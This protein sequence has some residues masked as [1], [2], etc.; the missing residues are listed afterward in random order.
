MDLYEP[1]LELYIKIFKDKWDFEVF[2]NTELEEKTDWCTYPK[3]MFDWD[4]LCYV[5]WVEWDKLD[6]F[7]HELY[8]LVS[9]IDSEYSLG[10]ETCAYLMWWIV[11]NAYKWTLITS[12]KWE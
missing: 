3:W 9:V 7:I 6:I 5:M 11:R 4:K 8:H 12:N 2:T 1:M 10:E